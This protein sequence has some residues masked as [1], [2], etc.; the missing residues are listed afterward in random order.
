MTKTKGENTIANYTTYP[1]NTSGRPSGTPAVAEEEGGYYYKYSYSWTSKSASHEV[2]FSDA[3]M[4]F[5]GTKVNNGY[6]FLSCIGTLSTPPEF[7][8]YTSPSFKG[9]WKCYTRNAGSGDINP[10]EN[11]IIP[12]SSSVSS[13]IYTYKNSNRIKI[14][15][16]ISGNNILGTIYKVTS[17]GEVALTSEHTVSGSGAGMGEFSSTNTFLVGVS[18]PPA[19]PTANCGN[20]SAYLKHVYIREGYLYSGKNYETPTEWVPDVGNNVTYYSIVVRPEYTTYN[21][22][23][24]RDEEVSISY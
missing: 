6:V 11:I 4:K 7:G 3:V 8:I 2:D 23:G 24:S 10:H 17:S 13:G 22:F 21:R 19:P 18:L 14:K 9:V 1:L 20:K 12:D 16:R 5:D 15:I